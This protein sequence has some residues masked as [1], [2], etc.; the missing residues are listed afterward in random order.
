MCTSIII[1]NCM[2]IHCAS[3]FLFKGIFDIL[4]VVHVYKFLVCVHA[5]MY[6][7]TYSELLLICHLPYLPKLESTT[8]SQYQCNVQVPVNIQL[9]PQTRYS[10]IFFENELWQ[11]NQ[12]SLYVYFTMV[13]Y[14]YVYIRVHVHLCVHVYVRMYVYYCMYTYVCVYYVIVHETVCII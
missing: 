5:H 3:K 10:T 8:I 6:L 11:I 14:L 13:M 4:H 9:I 7:R 1:V 2:N 12:Y